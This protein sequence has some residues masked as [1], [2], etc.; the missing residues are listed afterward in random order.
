MIHGDEDGNV[1]SLADIQGFV[2]SIILDEMAYLQYLTILLML[3]V[4][5]FVDF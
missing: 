4:L 5:D 1:A 2:N 3:G